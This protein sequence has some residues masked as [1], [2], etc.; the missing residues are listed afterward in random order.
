M[1]IDGDLIFEM[2]HSFSWERGNRKVDRSGCCHFSFR[3]CTLVGSIQPGIGSAL[4]NHVPLPGKLWV[5]ISMK[6]RCLEVIL[7]FWP[8]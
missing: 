1:K 6:L 7:S 3:C 4:G 8:G 2:F 5:G